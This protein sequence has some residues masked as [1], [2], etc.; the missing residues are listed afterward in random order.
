[1]LQQYAEGDFVWGSESHWSIS[2]K[3]ED[4]RRWL[5]IVD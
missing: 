1:M 5:N 4:V 3:R 2:N